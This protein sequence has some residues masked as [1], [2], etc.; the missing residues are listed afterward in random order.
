MPR[1]ERRRPGDLWPSTG[2]LCV[3]QQPRLTS[4]PDSFYSKGIVP[5]GTSKGG[6]DSPASGFDGQQTRV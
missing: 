1:T 2:V 3:V 6:T 4:H 5:T